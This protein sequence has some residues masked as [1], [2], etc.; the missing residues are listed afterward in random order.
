MGGTKWWL[1]SYSSKSKNYEWYMRKMYAT[2]S[3]WLR[4][5]STKLGYKSYGR[6]KTCRNS[7][8]YNWNC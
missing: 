8:E 6:I 2:W 4:K 1:N 3:N 7:M 5:L